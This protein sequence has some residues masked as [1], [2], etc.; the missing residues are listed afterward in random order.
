M[1]R[2]GR[3]G[4]RAVA[5]VPV[6]R[7]WVAFGIGGSGA[8]EADGQWSLSLQR[9][10][11]CYHR[12]R[13]VPRSEV[14]HP[15]ERP[16]V[17]QVVRFVEAQVEVVKRAVRSLLHPNWI[18]NLRV[19]R[20][21]VRWLEVEDPGDRRACCIQ[22]QALEPV[23]CVIA[24]E[25][26]ALVRAR[27]GATTVD[28]AADDACVSSCMRVRV[29]GVGDVCGRAVSL[30]E[31]PP[32]VGATLDE[33]QLLPS[34]RRVVAAD[35][36]DIHVAGDRIERE[37]IGVAKPVRPDLILVPA[38]SV[39]ERVVRRNGAV[40]IDAQDLAVVVRQRLGIRRKP[41]V[42]HRY[43]ELSVG[44]EADR[45]PVMYVGGRVGVVLPEHDLAV[46]DGCVP[47]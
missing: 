29:D 17:E 11:V 32:V 30:A 31:W 33:I 47:T 45:R 7:Q 22:R 28:E 44:P 12:W 10:A 9:R 42:A 15:P 38:V 14:P 36:A 46:R 19:I 24:D 2:I 3:R 16:G 6:V 8:R 5:E 39:D 25:E 26:V 34:R 4:G 18:S 13:L 23:L 43:V 40:G 1:R 21:A 20:C 35:V 27:I 41:V 37:S